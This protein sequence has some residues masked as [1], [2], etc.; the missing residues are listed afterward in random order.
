[1]NEF[2]VKSTRRILRSFGVDL[3]RYPQRTKVP[4]DFDEDVLKIFKFIEPY[5]MT[6]IERVHA[7][8]QAVRYVVANDIPGAFAECGVWRG[9]SAMAML[10][11][12]LALDCKT[13]DLFLFDTFEGMPPPSVNDRDLHGNSAEQ[14]LLNEDRTDASHLWAVCDLASARRNVEGVGYPPEHI[15]FVKGA[16]EQTIP[17]FAPEK[18]A[19]L[20][21]DTDWYES[22]RHELVHLFPKVVPGGVVI[23]DDYGHWGGARKAVDE[24]LQQHQLAF[25]L[26]RVDYTG[27]IGVKVAQ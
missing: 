10:K 13:R 22:T 7:V 16:V 19:I 21:L 5:T 27:R 25:F 24:Y 4:E 14:L 23:I 9:G 2:L 20:R 8:I 11:A 18:I 17:E 1:M 15:H 3:V 12:L 26:C 6:S